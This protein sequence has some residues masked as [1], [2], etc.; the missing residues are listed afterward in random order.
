MEPIP[1]LSVIDCFKYTFKVKSDSSSSSVNV[2][3]PGSGGSGPT[4]NTKTLL[5]IGKR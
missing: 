3:S 5:V 1:L 2:S 4:V